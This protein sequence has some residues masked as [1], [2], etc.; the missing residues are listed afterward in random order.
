MCRF[1]GHVAC[2][3]NCADKIQA[4]E[5]ICKSIHDGEYHSAMGF[6]IHCPL[7]RAPLD[8]CHGEVLAT[9]FTTA[10]TRIAEGSVVCEGCHHPKLTVDH[11]E[12]TCTNPLA[13]CPYGCGLQQRKA[14]L[15]SHHESCCPQRPC[16]YC[17]AKGPHLCAK[18]SEF[19]HQEN[20]ALK[21]QKQ[22][23]Q[24]ESILTKKD[25]NEARQAWFKE[26]ERLNTVLDKY[27]QKSE[28]LR[29][30]FQKISATHIKSLDQAKNEIAVLILN[31]AAAAHN[32]DAN[33][34]EEESE[35]SEE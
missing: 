23:L 3:M 28:S 13:F 32:N 18:E 34:D 27:K 7:C 21:L 22:T 33:N 8:I 20:E 14:L 29:V 24:A 10:Y 11:D 9:D 15:V 31:H 1:G 5:G 30:E 35:E 4:N 26:K 2:C 16:T 12:E 19:L 17:E 25:F 6:H